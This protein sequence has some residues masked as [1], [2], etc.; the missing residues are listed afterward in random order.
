MTYTISPADAALIRQRLARRE[1][2]L[3]SLLR[4]CT[5]DA[6]HAVDEHEVAD[7]KDMAVAETQAAVDEAQAAHAVAELQQLQL[8]RARLEDGHYGLCL[9]CGDEIDPRRLQALPGTAYC[10]SCQQAREHRAVR[11]G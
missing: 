11:A 6:V 2:E 7:F 1:A 8:A 3:R 5:V 10:P 9:D 4:A